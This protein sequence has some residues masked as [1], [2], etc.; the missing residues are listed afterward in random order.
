M[1]R[2]GYRDKGA[3]IRVQDTHCMPLK[4]YLIFKRGVYKEYKEACAEFVVRGFFC[5]FFLFF[6]F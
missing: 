5:C 3:E 6:V 1:Q 2:Q 4:V